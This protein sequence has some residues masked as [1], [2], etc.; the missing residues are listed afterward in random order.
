MTAPSDAATLD[1]GLEPGDP[2]TGGAERGTDTAPP[3]HPLVIGLD[4]SLASTGMSNGERTWTVRSRGSKNDSLYQRDERLRLLRA[5]I[6]SHCL[7]ARL[8]V[9]EGPSY[10]SANG[11]QHDRSGLF[12]MVV[13]ALRHRGIG[14]A[15]A[16]PSV[17]KKYA[18]GSGAASKGAV[19]EA[20]VQR[21]P[22][23]AI[24]GDDNRAD[25][26]WLHAMGVDH[27]T[28][29]AVVPA[30]HRIVLRKVGWPALAGDR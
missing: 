20:S 10:G 24:G 14:V 9:V 11:H 17:V 26:L 25:A 3:A 8:V 2:R 13:R 1:L 15:E 12:W 18:T 19:I 29:E 16:A 30:S 27:M 22:E 23:V 21:F 7:E 6:I 28:G 4:L 5:E